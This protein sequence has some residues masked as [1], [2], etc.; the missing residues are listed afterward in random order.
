MSLLL[1]CGIKYDYSKSAKTNFFKSLNSRALNALERFDYAY[2]DLS[3]L[4]KDYQSFLRVQ[5][6]EDEFQSYFR[7]SIEYLKRCNIEFNRVYENGVNLVELI[8]RMSIAD[9]TFLFTNISKTTFNNSNLGTTQKLHECIKSSTIEKWGQF[10]EIIQNHQSKNL[11]AIVGTYMKESLSNI[12][13][14]FNNQNEPTRDDLLNGIYF[15]KNVCVLH[16][17]NIK[18]HAEIF[19]KYFAASYIM[20]AGLLILSSKKKLWIINKLIPNA[21]AYLEHLNAPNL[22]GTAHEY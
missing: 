17:Y 19:C 15:L 10:V 5:E 2:F 20:K 8:S 16:R 4:M 21:S 11:D 7:N 14:Y 13:R 18:R 3:L 12:P 6:Y 9:L 1:S 22:S